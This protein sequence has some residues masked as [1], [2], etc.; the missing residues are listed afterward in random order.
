MQIYFLIKSLFHSEHSFYKESKR[1]HKYSIFKNEETAGQDKTLFF[2][3]IA[4]KLFQ[5]IS[6]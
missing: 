4:L 6:K 5:I 1:M 3:S 2:L